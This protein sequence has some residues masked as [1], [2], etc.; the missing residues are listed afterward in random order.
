MTVLAEAV[1]GEAGAGEA[2]G[3]V[4]GQERVVDLAVH[5]RVGV[6]PQVARA[7]GDPGQPGDDGVGLCRRHPGQDAGDVDERV[8]GPD[9]AEIEAVGGRRA[10]RARHR[11]Q[12]HGTEQATDESHG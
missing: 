4:V 12:G 7:R 6:Q 5:H 8:A 2:A 9:R 1:G 3:E 11:A 10:A